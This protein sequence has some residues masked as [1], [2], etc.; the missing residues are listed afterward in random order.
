M[1]EYLNNKNITMLKNKK[2]N[3]IKINFIVLL[4]L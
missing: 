2:L 1:N 3:F 4:K